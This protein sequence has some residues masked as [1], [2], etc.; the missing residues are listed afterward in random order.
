MRGNLDFEDK[1]GGS[2]VEGRFSH[3]GFRV[4]AQ[5]NDAGLRA[6]REQPSQP[7]VALAFSQGKVSHDYIGM[8]P[9]GAFHKRGF[10]GDCCYHLKLLVKQASNTLTQTVMP[11]CQQ[12]TSNL[13]FAHPLAIALSFHQGSGKSTS[14]NYEVV[15]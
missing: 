2:G 8:H 15:S 14:K 12:H 13:S 3:G 1:A 11:I 5:N 10:V 4:I 7:A 9:N 6:T